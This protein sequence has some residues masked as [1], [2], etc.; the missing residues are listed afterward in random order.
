MADPFVAE[1]R[2]FTLDFAP[3]NWA[4]C[5]GQLVP[6]QQNTAL[7]SLLGVNFGGNG[8]TNFGLPNMQGAAPM[9]AGYGPGLSNRRL[10]E[11]GGSET[12]T[13]VASQV[14]AH[15][16]PV[17]GTEVSGNARSP[18][19]GASLA[20]TPGAFA[21]GGP[22][23]TALA[24]AAIGAAGAGAPHQNMQPFL[25]VNFCIALTGEYPSRW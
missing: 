21:A 18:A 22:L 20:A 23:D 2:I 9:G 17:T 24:P 25:S 11:K 14:P 10:G 13:L 5:N 7:F 6:V 4:F 15:S 1:I 3:R 8:T 19:G 16:H 12:V